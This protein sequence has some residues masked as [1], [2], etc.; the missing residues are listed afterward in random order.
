MLLIDQG[1]APSGSIQVVV[2]A[3][4]V[5]KHTRSK[6]RRAFRPDLMS[7]QSKGA[8]VELRIRL[9]TASI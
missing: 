2:R 7:Q 5:H 1:L 3:L 6:A 4:S 9:H 8:S